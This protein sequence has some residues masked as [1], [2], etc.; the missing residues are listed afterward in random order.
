MLMVNA[1]AGTGKTSTGTWGLG[2]RVPR[3]VKVSDE[4]K[5]IIKLMREYKGTQA[6]M[7]FNRSIADKLAEEAPV[8]CV[9]NTSNGFGH[10]V[11]A[12]H[13]QTRKLN[14]DGLKNRK[15][16][17]ELIGQSLPWK[18]RMKVE[19]SVDSLVSLCKCYLFDPCT[20]ERENWLGGDVWVDG[21]GAM[22]WLCD[23][24]DIDSDISVLDYTCRTFTKGLTTGAY[25][26]FDDQNFMP[27]YH[28][29]KMP[30]YDH[31]LVD[32]VQD[33][34]RAKQEMAFRMAR[35]ITAVGDK[36]QAIYGFSG[37][38]SDAMANMWKRMQ[39][40]DSEAQNLPLTITRRNPRKV[41]ER[42]NRWV[43]ELRAREDAPDGI[44]ENMTMEQFHK[45]AGNEPSMVVCRI[46]AP[47][48]SLAFKL[49][50]QGKRCYIQG[51]DIGSGL[52]SEIKKTGENDL[53]S[54]L[55]KV[56]DRIERRKMEISQRDFP[57]ENQ[58]EALSDKLLCIDIL[59]S[60]VDT[61]EEFNKTVDD[62][63]KDKGNDKTDTRLS[64]VHKAKGLEHPKVY[65][66][67]SNRLGLKAKKAYQTEQEKNLAYVA[68]TRSMSE[69]YLIPEEKK[70]K[71]YDYE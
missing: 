68:D 36:H 57:D 47:L 52:K 7:A 37:A 48:S 13:L 62:L 70:A 65:V 19:S 71:E 61:I 29:V 55:I 16:C 40:V 60:N 10:R 51:R 58:I 43:P 44:V 67:M 12:A 64:S 17:R 20:S 33:L 9:C 35:Q 56:H 59:A 8:S 15:L 34:N 50:A 32:E 38:D 24:F 28:N 25:I 53:R 2:A 3:G 31:V 42:A 46:N 26:D 5:A 45:I 49:L 30:T 41:V 22:K 66:Y 69:L 39:E 63:F 21:L 27:I 1:L 18:E 23:R 4:Q 11:W 54:A 6:A 14:V